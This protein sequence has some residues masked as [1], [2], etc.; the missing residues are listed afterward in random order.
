MVNKIIE[1][2]P[3]GEEDYGGKNLSI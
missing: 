3:K 2:N 1:I